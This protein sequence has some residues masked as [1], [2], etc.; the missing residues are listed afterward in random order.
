VS[1]L[2]VAGA[3]GIFYWAQYRGLALEESRTL[4]VNTIVAMEIFYLFSVRFQHEP[5]I[6]WRGILGTRAV[7]LGVALVTGLQFAF[8][9]APFMQIMFETRPVGLIDGTMTIAVG[10]GLLLVLEIEKLVLKHFRRG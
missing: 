4:V 7:L 5:S 2:F 9:Y 1:I 8:T 6:T 10:V 3:F